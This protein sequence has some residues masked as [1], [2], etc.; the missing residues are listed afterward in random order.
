[1]RTWAMEKLGDVAIRIINHYLWAKGFYFPRLE[2]FLH[3]FTVPVL[4]VH[5]FH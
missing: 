3:C 2:Q 5:P 4:C 1:M